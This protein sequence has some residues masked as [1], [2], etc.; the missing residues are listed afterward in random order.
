MGNEI[1]NIPAEP[2]VIAISRQDDKFRAVC[3]GKKGGSFEVL[4]I[5]SSES[6]QSNWRSF[7]AECGLPAGA[8]EQSETDTGRM[9]VAGF[10]S[11]GVI[12]YRIDMPRVAQEEIAA[13]VKLQAEAR[14]PLPAEQIEMTWRPGRAQV[15][16]VAVTIAA[17]K[18]EQLQK[19]VEDVRG[20]EPAK[21]MLDCEGLVRVWSEIF[22][23]GYKPAVVA[24]LGPRSTQLCLAEDGKLTNAVILD[25]GMEDFSAPQVGNRER[26]AQDLTNALELFGYAEPAK[27]PV[28][29]LSD[30]D[31]VME[32]IV[33]SLE[34]A[35]LDAKE[36][37][38]DVKKLKAE[39]DLSAED[40]YE[41]RVPIGL[42]LMAFDERADELN[43]FERLYRPAGAEER[44]HWSY[45]PKITTVIA[46]AMLV[47]MVAVFY[48]V[49]VT[50]LNAIEK[51][52]E[53]T[54]SQTNHNSLMQRQKLIKEVAQQRP[55]ILQ[56]LREI[57]V[58][59]CQGMLLDSFNF[60]KGQTV[61]ITGQAKDSEQLYK[62]QKALLDKKGITAVKIQNATKDK[63]SNKIKFTITFHYKGFTKKKSR[64]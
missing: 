15:G 14:L 41:Y 6:A 1:T 40:I 25:M 19:F 57:N 52:L 42:A 21:I 53:Q 26:F 45:S 2:S 43:I 12:F 22:S 28:F 13:V 38:P 64:T 17:A 27:V 4:W 46:A 63:K 24:G 37:L 62:F 51:H 39:T 11:A 10:N 35:G 50:K 34:S 54:K 29:V 8:A 5:K 16:Q 20:F 58:D 56:L 60:R 3:L 31:A 36:V 55:N 59:D 7:A 61:N 48:L 33:S 44:K 47:L 49:D 18:K 9:V 32:E 30:G 23:G